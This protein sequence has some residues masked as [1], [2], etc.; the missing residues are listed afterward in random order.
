MKTRIL[1]VITC[2][3]LTACAAAPPATQAVWTGHWT[4]DNTLA[5]ASGNGGDA[6]VEKP[7][8]V[9]GIDGQ[10]LRLTERMIATVPDA[11]G[12]RLTRGFRLACRVRFDRLPAGN[13]W[14][15]VAT[16]GNDEEGEY[17]LRVDPPSEG[18]RFGCFVNTGHWEPRVQSREPVK[19]GVWYEIEVGWDGQSLWMTVN[20]DTTRMARR[21]EPVVTREPLRLGAF[22]G[23]L[24][25][26]RISSPGGCFTGVAN[27]PFNGDLHD[28]SGHGHD[29][30]AK[31]STFAP[32]AGGQA[33]LPGSGAF[34]TPST[35]DLQ[36]APGLRLDCA[37]LFKSLPAG[38]TPIVVK[39]GEYMLRLGT[40][41][42]GSNLEFFVKLNGAWEPR[43]RAECR[44]EPDMWYRVIAQWDG[45]ALTL[46]VNGERTE[47]LRSGRAAPG[48]AP[49]TLGRFNGLIANLRL[50]NPKPVVVRLTELSTESTLLRAGRPEWL[51]GVV[52]NYGSATAGCV[53]TLE[54]PPG[55]SCE[56]PTRL[57]LAAC[58]T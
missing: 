10:A 35:P 28:A 52:R 54:P 21:G 38:E 8:F 49:L 3:S 51:S 43:V 23:A 13:A 31:K 40:Q 20:G 48:Q 15:T 16:K 9:H 41:A 42:E 4:F 17:F 55:I 50:E 11:P 46:D 33:L 44:V 47:M 14:A 37:V 19:P 29:F 32:V 57:D 34:T 58:R 2:C 12:L 53:V 6:Y 5:D 30:A 39:E 1:A 24:E 56:T 18:R 22:D 25:D 27:W 45:L 26:L 7:V 36:L